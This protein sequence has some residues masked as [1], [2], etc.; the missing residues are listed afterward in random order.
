MT[1]KKPASVAALDLEGYEVVEAEALDY[2][3]GQR[4]EAREKKW[5]FKSGDRVYRIKP[6]DK[7]PFTAEEAFNRG[8]WRRW[9]A[10]AL[11]DPTQ[12]DAMVNELGSWWAGIVQHLTRAVAAGRGEEGSSSES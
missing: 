9:A 10:G 1:A 12:I 7:W 11:V 3:N 4:N 2:T 8:E 6:I 5:A